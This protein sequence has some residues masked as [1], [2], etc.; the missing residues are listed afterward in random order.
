MSIHILT[1]KCLIL[2]YISFPASDQL[3]YAECTFI[4]LL[5]VHDTI[6]NAK[7]IKENTICCSHKAQEI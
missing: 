1:L 7:H 6:M 5:N 3:N 4:V 2:I